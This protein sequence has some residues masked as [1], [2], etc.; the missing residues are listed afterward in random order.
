MD[1][2]PTTGTSVAIFLL[3]GWLGK[4]GER[5]MMHFGGHRDQQSPARCLFLDFPFFLG[6]DLLVAPEGQK[7]PGIFPGLAGWVHALRWGFIWGVS[8]SLVPGMAGRPATPCFFRIE[9]PLSR[10]WRFLCFFVMGKTNPYFAVL[11][12]N[13]EGKGKGLGMTTPPL[14]LERRWRFPWMTIDLISGRAHAANGDG[15]S[16]TIHT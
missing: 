11:Q 6:D 15:P 10:Y 14:R 9:M 1:G 4:R 2:Q 8:G 7:I 13:G 12:G 16:T 3:H 5:F